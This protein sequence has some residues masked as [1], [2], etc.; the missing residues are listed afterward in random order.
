MLEQLRAHRTTQQEGKYPFLRGSHFG[1]HA[2]ADTE[3]RTQ[4]PI[5]LPACQNAI[6]KEIKAYENKVSNLSSI[7]QTL[8]SKLA[9]R[10]VDEEEFKML[11]IEAKEKQIALSDLNKSLILES[12]KLDEL[13]LKLESIKEILD[14]KNNFPFH[15]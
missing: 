7:I 2:P 1:K 3:G 13:K 9:G 12:K 14:K 15:L 4:I 8:D 11:E 6:E 5:G 10:G